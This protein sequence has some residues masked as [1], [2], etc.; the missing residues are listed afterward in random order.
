MIKSNNIL[1][2]FLILITLFE[3]LLISHRNGF[4]QKILLNFY[5]S[6][7]GILNSLNSKY[8]FTNEIF[9]LT[10]KYKIL[11]YD[12][13]RE[14]IIS[15][16]AAIQRLVE[17]TYPSRINYKSNFFFTKNENFVAANCI[18]LEKLN[19]ITLYDCKK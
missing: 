6:N 4:D 3:F 19:S 14:L 11:N 5:K 8:Y 2:F 13:D 17:V 1:N 15:D 9:L 7:Y 16:P 18:F 12:V 10:Q